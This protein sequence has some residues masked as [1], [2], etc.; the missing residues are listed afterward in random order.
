M[1][2]GEKMAELE[3]IY[4]KKTSMELIDL[5][6][7]CRK[8]KDELD[9]L[10]SDV[11][12]HYDYLRYTAIPQKFD[13]EGIRNLHVE[14]IGR[15]GLTSGIYASIKP[16]RKFDAYQFLG[17]TGRGDIITSTVNA[18]TLAAT[19]KQMMQKGEDVPEELFTVTPWTRASITKA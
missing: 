9:A 11:N 18:Q 1:A 4:S 16:D 5:M 14:G 6:N 2:D 10:L 19:L 15:I 3:S 8:K 13:D 12:A 7:R 17:D